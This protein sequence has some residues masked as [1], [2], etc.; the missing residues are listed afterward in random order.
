MSNLRPSAFSADKIYRSRAWVLAGTAGWN[1]KSNG[2]LY[3]SERS[4]A[5][6]WK[7]LRFDEA[8]DERSR[9]AT[10]QTT[11]YPPEHLAPLWFVGSV[12]KYRRLSQIVIRPCSQ[13]WHIRTFYSWEGTRKRELT[14]SIFSDSVSRFRLLVRSTSS[15]EMP[16]NEEST[17]EFHQR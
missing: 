8:C 2:T 5:C 3:R 13:G 10:L 15:K 7:D 14:R 17:E 9:F 12:Y 6:P 16:R 11:V 1:R 4:N